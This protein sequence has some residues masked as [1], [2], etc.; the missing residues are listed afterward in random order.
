[1]KLSPHA[2]KKEPSSKSQSPWI[3][4]EIKPQQRMQVLTE[5]IRGEV[6]RVLGMD[7]GEMI[8]LNRGLFE[9][10]MDSLMSVELKSRL[11]ARL[12]KPLPSTL[13]FNYPSITALAD[14]ISRN[15]LGFKVEEREASP[16]EPHSNVTE[17][18]G[19]TSDL[20]ED[21]LE[22]LLLEKLKQL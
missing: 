12:G 16:L 13:T 7:S 4:D 8:D 9:M 14:F 18:H 1:M 3:F 15:I 6:A 17:F 2:P 11:Q 21:E 22:S 19:N 20:S 5:R 10:G